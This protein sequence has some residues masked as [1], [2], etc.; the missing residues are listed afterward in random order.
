MFRRWQDGQAAAVPTAWSTS[1]DP[2]TGR[3]PDGRGHAARGKP[4]N[5]IGVAL[6]VPVP[7]VALRHGW[8]GPLVRH[9]AGHAPHPAYQPPVRVRAAPKVVSPRPDQAFS[10]PVALSRARMS[11][12]PSPSMSPAAVVCEK[13]QPPVTLTGELK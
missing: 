12:L 10:V 2:P 5:R 8:R 13:L 11:A 7:S 6:Q 1:T 4:T 9:C 3:Y